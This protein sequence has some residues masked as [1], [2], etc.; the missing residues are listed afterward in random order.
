MPPPFQVPPAPCRDG[1]PL[2][3][4]ADPG[5]KSRRSAEDGEFG[6]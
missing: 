5:E 6:L 1:R 3:R 2:P 4:S